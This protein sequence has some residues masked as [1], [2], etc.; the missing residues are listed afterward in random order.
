MSSDRDTSPQPTR[1]DARAFKPRVNK[2][3]GVFMHRKGLKGS[4]VSDFYYR[5]MVASWTQFFV[6]AVLVYLSINAGFA[7]IYYLSGDM[8]L[9][10]RPGSFVDAYIFSFQTSTT[11]GYGYLLPK[12]GYAHAIVMVDVFSG[13]I[14]VAVLTGLVFARL[15]KPRASVMFSDNVVFTKHA[16]QDA[17][18]VRL[19]SGRKHSSIVNT[20]VN[21]AVVMVDASPDSKIDR[22]F[23]DLT[24]ER[25]HI[26]IFSFTWT[27]IHI[28]DQHSPLY[29][30]DQDALDEQVVTLI[31]TLDGIEDIFAQTVHTH[32]IYD[33][34]S[35]VFDK[36]FADLFSVHADGNLVIDY[37]RFNTLENTDGNDESEEL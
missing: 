4:L 18:L 13:L 3:G 19:A 12:N 27:L 33:T 30:L 10:A 25:D 31:V 15:A 37:T 5:V 24:L 22:R 16:G 7:L 8:I 6:A 20:R 32:Q 2:A 21:A 23:F 35:F 36:E 9:N 34:K 29:G 14:F 11:I 1:A 26:P 28:I 17:L